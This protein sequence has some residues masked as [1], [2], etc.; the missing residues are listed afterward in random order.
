MTLERCSLAP[1]G[2]A[3][4]KFPARAAPRSAR[5][6]AA[7]A[8]AAVAAG[9]ARSSTVPRSVGWARSN[10]ISSDP[11]PPPTSTT[12]P[13]VTSRT[14]PRPMAPRLPIVA[15]QRVVGG[16]PSGCSARSSQNPR[17]K[18]RERPARR[19][20]PNA[21]APPCTCQR[22]RSRPP[23][24]ST[25]EH[26]RVIVAQPLSRIGQRIGLD[27]AAQ[28]SSGHEMIQQ[29]TSGS[30]ATA[31]RPAS[32]ALKSLPAVIASATRSVAATRSA[33]GVI[34][35]AAGHSGPPHAS[36][37]SVPHQPLSVAMH[38]YAQR[39]RIHRTYP[40]ETEP[41]NTHAPN[42]AGQRTALQ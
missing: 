28:K 1:A 40:I 10:A 19:S 12:S 17:P 42:S 35:S 37:C 11:S 32:S 39:A 7:K 9:D 13:S 22:A 31:K 23:D 5:P 21:A 24:R 20:E 6:A 18:C 16:G 2:N 30:A 14:R 27:V 38:L 26:L 4:K 36:T 41:G 3:S 34:R 25:P 15:H 29:R 8:R 33:I